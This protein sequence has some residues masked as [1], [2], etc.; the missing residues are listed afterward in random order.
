MTRQFNLLFITALSCLN[1]LAFDANAQ[2]LQQLYIGNQGNFSDANGSVTYLDNPVFGNNET[3]EL[4]L[5][6]LVQSI[7]FATNALGDTAGYVMSNTSDRIDII[8]LESTQ[9]GQI[10]DVPSPR[11]M[12]QVTPR[13]AYVSNL[14]ANTI[15][16]ID[17]N[18]NTASGTIPVGLNPEGIAISNGRAFIAN[19]GFGLDSTLTVIDIETDTIQDTLQLGCDNPR[20]VYTD[21]VGDIWAFC[22]GKV[23]Y[24]SDFSEIIDQTDAAIVVIDGEE[25][26]IRNQFVLDGQ[27][28]STSGGQDA[29]M[30]NSGF[31][32]YYIQDQ[33]ILSFDTRNASRSDTLFLDEQPPIGAVAS[34]TAGDILTSHIPSFTEAGFVL[35]SVKDSEETFSWDTGIAPSFI[36]F[37]EGTPPVSNERAAQNI[38]SVLH[39]NYP[40]PARTQTTFRATLP[41]AGPVTLQVFDLL[42]RIVDTP[43]RGFTPAGELSIPWSTGDLAPGVYTY[44][45][46]AGERRH[47]DQLIILP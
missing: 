18:N 39:S 12:A 34:T 5:N 19:S 6:T 15:T 26:Q 20:M 2:H 14:F 35:L 36:A 32:A 42:G 38:A 3:I 13:K 10:L 8:N 16:I 33:T 41:A 25:V 29:F 24:N 37:T 4:E 22:N 11:F 30:D 47:A 28:G 7:T 21:S 1:Y 23:E 43:H 31:V 46:T 9:V 44:V 27:A 45:L 40:N 17:L